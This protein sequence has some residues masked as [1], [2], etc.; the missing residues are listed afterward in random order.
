M[1]SRILRSCF[2]SR[3]KRGSSTTSPRIRRNT[4]SVIS[5]SR[6]DS[7]RPTFRTLSMRSMPLICLRTYPEAPAMIE[8]NSASSSA[9]EVSISTLM[10]GQ[11]D[12]ISR[13]AST[14]FPSGRRT[15]IT[16]ISGVS[17][18][19]RRM[20]SST[21]PASPTTVMSGSA[22]SIAFT[23]WRTTSW[24]STSSIR[25]ALV[26]NPRYRT[27]K[28]EFRAFGTNTRPKVPKQRR[29]RLGRP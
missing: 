8:A 4:R 13:H 22:S 11:R 16:T 23:P 17:K 21:E 1:N 20:A 6:S 3:D 24:S 7:P 12:R 25:N 27:H 19:T 18:P 14:P 5:G 29:I 15:S 26:T 2:D 28:H 10:C 9:K